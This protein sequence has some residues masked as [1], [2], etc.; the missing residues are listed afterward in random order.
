MKECSER[1]MTVIKEI[2]ER[3]SQEIT[4]ERWK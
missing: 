3:K 4:D 2:V 1:E